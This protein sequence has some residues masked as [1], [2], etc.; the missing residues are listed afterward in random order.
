MAATPTKKATTPGLKQSSPPYR[1]SS[2]GEQAPGTTGGVK[3]QER[4]APRTP[5]T[6]GTDYAFLAAHSLA[7]FAGRFN[8]SST[9][10]VVNLDTTSSS[11]P[12]ATRRFFWSRK[13]FAFAPAPLRGRVRFLLRSS[14]S[15]HD[16][17][18]FVQ[19]KRPGRSDFLPAEP[20]L[21]VRPVPL[22]N[23]E[24]NWICCP[25]HP[26]RE[27]NPPPFASHL[28]NTSPP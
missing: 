22:P 28:L 19:L 26:A 14:V 18:S 6:A 5:I 9:S 8:R 20:K 21:K 2:A 25:A 10:R 7:T 15:S 3:T 1:N 17:K 12:S 4:G 13:R 23:P 27:S 11:I 16:S 24:V